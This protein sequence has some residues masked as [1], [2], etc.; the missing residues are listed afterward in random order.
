MNLLAWRRSRERPSSLALPIRRAAFAMAMTVALLGSTTGIVLTFYETSRDIDDENRYLAAILSEVLASDINNQAESLSD[1]SRS[2][3]VSSALTDSAGMRAYLE[4]FLKSRERNRPGVPVKLY[5]YRGRGILGDLPLTPAPGSVDRV[6]QRVLESGA[7]A[8]DVVGGS[9]AVLLAAYPVAAPYSGITTAVVVGAVPIGAMLSAQRQ[10]LPV[11]VGFDLLYHGTHVYSSAG[12]ERSR[13]FPTEYVVPMKSSSDD[14][15]M[16]LRLYRLEN[17]LF[18]PV[19]NRVLMALI[20]SALFGIGAWRVA[21]VVASRLTMR[22]RRLAEACQDI[23]GGHAGAIA[24]DQSS[25]EIGVLSRALREALQSYQHVA[26]HLEQLVQE[27][28]AALAQ[29]QALFRTAIEALDEGFAIYDAQ[30]C[31]VY[32]NERYVQTYRE[33]ADLIRPG[34]QY[35]TIMRDWK[36]AVSPRIGAAELQ[37][38]VAQRVA[39]HARGDSSIGELASG[40]WLRTADRR[41]PDGHMVGVHMDISE[42][43][44]ARQLAEAANEAK[45]RFLA[46][47]SH[48]IRTPLNGVLGMAQLLLMPGLTEADRQA[49]A[50][51]VLDSGTALMTVLN[52]ILD[53]SKI[54]AGRLELRPAAAAPAG[55][56]GGVIL[57]F[58]AVAQAKGLRLEGHW[59]GRADAAYEID[60]ARVRQILGNLVS[61]AIKFTE[62]GLVSIRGVEVEWDGEV[63]VLEFS[64][65]DSGSGIAPE[66]LP[67]LFEPFMQVDSSPTRQFGGTGLG[68]SIVRQL[69]RAMGGDAHV[70]SRPGAGS[71]FRVRIRARQ[72]TRAVLPPM[73]PAPPPAPAPAAAPAEAAA[74]VAAR[75]RSARV[76]IVEDNAINRQVAAGMMGVLGFAPEF[77]FDGQE[78]LAAATATTRPDLVL[79]DCE[80]PVLSGYEA[81]RRIR[82]WETDHG[83]PRVPIVAITADAFGETHERCTAAG[84]DDVLTKPLSIA[85]LRAMFVRHLP[86]AAAEPLAAPAP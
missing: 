72:A 6:V 26:E 14:R 71:T 10:R 54:E 31:I 57:L 43:I 83:A 59:A 4:P 39:A 75:A 20:V 27:K 7:T 28:T 22:L 84:M 17:P 79:M 63:A 78:G 69:A 13:H 61:N 66:Y 62:T 46:T 33:V 48:E 38:W 29:Q 70:E 15:A 73:P 50:Q 18:A 3:L 36:Q 35:E 1:L 45:S 76:L 53:L 56:I 52:E 8:S 60:V 64:V 82:Q 24:P 42:L 23:P 21:D 85:D 49:Y 25:D 58:E 37:A 68:L 9:D 67:R 2:P 80:M 40:V 47:M 11:E 16:V 65:S 74:P 77:A 12:N 81:V 32:C 19:L 51:V 44:R 5:D 30:D 86:G 55:V 34:A 41:T